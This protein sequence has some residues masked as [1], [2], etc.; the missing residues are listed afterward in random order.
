MLIRPAI[1]RFRIKRAVLLIVRLSEQAP[2]IYSANVRIGQALFC[3][4]KNGLVSI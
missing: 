1:D 4:E 2:T 3:P